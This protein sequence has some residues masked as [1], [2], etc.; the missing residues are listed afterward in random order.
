MTIGIGKKN[1]VSLSLPI[2]QNK[3]TATESTASANAWS[4]KAAIEKPLA[5]AWTAVKESLR[6]AASNVGLTA[7]APL[8]APPIL[9]RPVVML[10][11]LT[12][13]ANSFDPLA[14]NLA[15]NK[16]NGPFATYVA[17]EGVF[18]LGGVDGRVLTD[19]EASK[20]KSFQMEYVDAKA[21]PSAKATQ[22]T[23]MLNKVSA[24]TKSDS[25]DVVTHS[26]G[27][28]DFRTYLDTRNGTDSNVKINSATMIGP[29]S[30]GTV[31]GNIGS[32]VGA[33]LGLKEASDELG[34]GDASVKKLDSTWEK[35]RNQIAK[36]VTIIAISGAPT[37]GPGGIQTGD[38]YVQV[39]E[40]DMKNANTIVLKGADPTP[41]AHLKEVGYSGVV[42][43]VQKALG[44]N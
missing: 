41:I 26:A 20:I 4:P 14:N 19:A 1:S 34:I 27:G 31:M 38:G 15:S 44:R 3:P 24:L 12:M 7:F 29:V 23:A 40:I 10:P 36:E 16:S 17:K 37:M 18:R 25:V 39:D 8:E 33:V 28:H 11:G 42:N 30:H 22:V 5:H 43:E 2:A 9:K 32:A 6:S 13:K 21:A 35:Q